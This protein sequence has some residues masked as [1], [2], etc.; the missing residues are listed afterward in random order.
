MGIWCLFS[1]VSNRFLKVKV[2]W[3]RVYKAS[4][5]GFLWNGC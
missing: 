5:E 4:E 1:R 2:L 3:G